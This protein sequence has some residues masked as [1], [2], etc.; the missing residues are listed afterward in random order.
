MFCFCC[1]SGKAG[2]VSNKSSVCYFS[3]PCSDVQRFRLIDPTPDEGMNNGF[4]L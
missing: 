3:I 1:W 4:E 2:R